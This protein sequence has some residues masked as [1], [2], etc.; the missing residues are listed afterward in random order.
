[1]TRLSKPILVN[2]IVNGTVVKILLVDDNPSNLEMAAETVRYA[3][4][5]PILTRDGYQALDVLDAEPVQFMIVDWM[6]PEMNGIELIRRVR[7][8]FSDRYIYIIMLTAKSAPDEVVIGL[9]SG[10]DDYM[11]KPFLPREMRARIKTGVRIVQH[12]AHL[13]NSLEE[14][15]SLATR[16]H[17]TGLYNRRHFLELLESA[18]ITDPIVSLMMLDV[19]HFKQV[20][21][22]FGHPVGD[23]V[24]KRITTICQKR[25]VEINGIMGRYGGEEFIALIPGY[26][27][28]QTY[29]FADSLR[30]QIATEVIDT[31]E[32]PLSVTVSIGIASR[33]EPGSTSPDKLIRAADDALYRAKGEGR[34]LVKVAL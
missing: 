9:E 10:A 30:Q 27:S 8:Q 1:M 14:M 16:D 2:N 21:D 26:T 6:M 18:L 7:A 4:H 32:G 17:L 20:N 34:N 25:I 29:E 13:S 3:G 12:A 5:E 23:V 22:T 33:N 31:E 24:L 11:R 28:M 15:Q 19:D